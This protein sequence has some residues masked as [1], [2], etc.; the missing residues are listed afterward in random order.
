M[1]ATLNNFDK[2]FARDTIAKLLE[3]V[4]CKENMRRNRCVRKR[5]PSRLPK[6]IRKIRKV[7]CR[8]EQ[9]P[10]LIEKDTTEA[11]QIEVGKLTRDQTE[12][13]EIKEEG[14]GNLNG[15]EK[16]AETRG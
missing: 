8:E 2:D 6:C 13:L 16:Q 14:G 1:L 9:E 5:Q 7:L 15:K 12:A 11:V 4:M 10:L 3:N